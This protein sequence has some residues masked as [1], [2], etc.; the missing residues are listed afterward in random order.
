MH[1]AGATVRATT[2]ETS[3]EAMKATIIDGANAPTRPPASRI[4]SDG[5]GDD[6]RRDRQRP[7]RRDRGLE[8]DRGDPGLPVGCGL[9]SGAGLHC[10]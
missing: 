10:E 5:A 4:G 9:F 6:E 7:T 2:I 8:D 1:R 3:T